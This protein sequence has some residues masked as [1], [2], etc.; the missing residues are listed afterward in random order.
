MKIWVS[1]LV[2]Y[3]G[4]FLWYTDIGG[5]LDKEEIE[6]FLEKF[7][8][9]ASANSADPE[10]YNSQKNLIKRFMEEDTGRQF[11]MVNNID[12]DDD[13][14]DVEGAEPGESAERLLDRYMEHMYAQLLKR[15]CHPVFAGNAVHPSMDLVGIEGAEIWDRAALMRY[16]SRR[17]F[18]EVVTHPN[19]GSKHAFK[20]AAME[21]TIAY[22]V[23]TVLYL[24]DPRFLLAL[25]L[26]ILGLFLQNRVKQ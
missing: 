17:A 24:G 22:P 12:M 7:E 6:F 20:V 23:E 16:K 14:E 1:L 25:I 15:A 9:N 8:E 19:M 13:P 11:L 21:K 4:F 3:A 18:M 26:I 2:I 5:K 10:T